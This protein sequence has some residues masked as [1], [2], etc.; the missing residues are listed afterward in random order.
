MTTITI[1]NNRNIME[2]TGVWIR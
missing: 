1:I 2:G